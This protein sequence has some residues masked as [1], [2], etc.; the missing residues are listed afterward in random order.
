MTIKVTKNSQKSIK[1]YQKLSE[2]TRNYQKLS[3]TTR[4]NSLKLTSTTNVSQTQMRLK[5][6]NGHRIAYTLIF[7]F[8]IRVKIFC[9]PWTDQTAR[10]YIQG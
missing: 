3:E 10:A 5:H 2:T 6:D 8:I 4:N 1:N 7:A 9:S